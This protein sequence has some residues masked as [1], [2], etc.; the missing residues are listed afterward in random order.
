MVA[1]E[2]GKFKRP[3][4]KHLAVLHGLEPDLIDPTRRTTSNVIFEQHATALSH[5][6][7]RPGDQCGSGRADLRRRARS[8]Q[9]DPVSAYTGRFE[10]LC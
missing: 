5:G 3:R 4:M 8:G 2:L 7:H 10:T 1:Q 9:A 6:G